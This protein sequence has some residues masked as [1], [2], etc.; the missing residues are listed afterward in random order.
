MRV[1]VHFS[2]KT[3]EEEGQSLSEILEAM[4]TNIESVIILK[5]GKVTLE[6]EVSD[7]DTLELVNVAS[8]G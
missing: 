2:G 6:E 4:G 5:D 8:G 3:C 7:G 1:K